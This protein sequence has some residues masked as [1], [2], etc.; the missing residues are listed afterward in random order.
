MQDTS[1]KSTCIC[2]ARSTRVKHTPNQDSLSILIAST[3]IM[4]NA[5]KANKS[6]HHKRRPNK[7]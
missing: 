3:A 4:C 5:R 6:S 7:A 2:R 1:K